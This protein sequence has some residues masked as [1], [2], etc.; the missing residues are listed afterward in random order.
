MLL[1]NRTGS[2]VVVIDG[3][4]CPHYHHPST[5]NE[6]KAIENSIRILYFT[7]LSTLIIIIIIMRSNL[8]WR[9]APLGLASA[10][11][12]SLPANTNSHKH[13]GIKGDRSTF[14]VSSSASTRCTS[15][16]TAKDESNSDEISKSNDKPKKKVSPKQRKKKPPSS[17]QE[18]RTKK[19]IKNKK[20][21]EMMEQLKT[22]LDEKKKDE[23][24]PKNLMDNL[25][26]F[27]VGQNVRKTL[28]ELTTLGT[29]LP[30]ETRQK[31]YLDERF[32]EGDSNA[33]FSEHNPFLERMQQDDYV[34]EV[35]VIGATGEVGT[36]VVRKLLLEGRFRVRVL[37]RDLYSH[38]L[39]LLGTG[40]TY[41]QGDLGN[42][43]SLEYALTDVDKIV[44]CAG[45][46]RPDERDFQEKFQYFV[47]ENLK[48]HV[49][50]GVGDHDEETVV[51]DME[52]EQLD[53]I[54]EVRA[55]LAEQVDYIGMLNLVRAYQNV[56]VAD[57]GTSQA[58][59]RTLF[60]F[61][62]RVED[63]DLFAVDEGNAFAK[64]QEKKSPEAERKQTKAP[65]ATYDYE[66][67]DEMA[68]EAPYL[69]Y[70]DEDEEGYE[71]EYGC[72]E[73]RLDATVKAQVRWIRNGLGRGVFVGKVPKGTRFGVSGEAAIV[74]SRLRSRED[75]E[76]GIDLST[77]GF[78]GF[79][80]KLVADG[81]TYE[82]FV[83]TG[84]YEEDGVEYIC[85][86]Y[87]HTKPCK[88]SNKSRNKSMIAR[89]PFNNFKPVLKRGAN[90]DM[91]DS[92]VETF[93]GKDVRN[94][95]FR[96]R[97]AS[98]DER[99]GRE[100]GENT[101][102]YMAISH[103]KVFRQQ[104]EPEFVYLSDAR[105]PREVKNGMVRHDRRRLL[106]ATEK[107]RGNREIVQILDQKALKNVKEM[108]RSEEETY[109]KFRGEETLKNSGLRW[110]RC[111]FL[112][113]V[114]Y[115]LKNVT[116]P[117]YLPLL[118]LYDHP[119]FRF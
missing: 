21:A 85:E 36:L 112:S 81:G 25:N 80:V 106:S 115:N 23:S 60:K 97:S 58:A 67:E 75:P 94:I 14:G 86:F 96:Y 83:R 98:N 63:F 22:K 93:T 59:K 7:A 5:R 38:T 76:K 18:D 88:Y 104:P 110:V 45:T 15:L 87:T 102:F 26:P 46:P 92:V 111:L 48:K 91:N 56:R 113:A 65:V 17:S 2:R 43:E 61:T 66:E 70:F 107:R 6:E 29:G 99:S 114:A 30:S 13:V 50:K 74:S 95:G 42:M 69:D 62:S 72:L 68:D 51:D 77:A 79:I 84:S 108:T 10:F 55:Q 78:G 57:Y 109:Y 54:L 27:Q 52:W 100:E 119:H 89:L 16:P 39:N 49:V 11:L 71:D 53:S 90:E 12:D 19:D 24:S 33:L 105:I 32:L 1:F 82:A 8:I 28:D 116:D 3:Y 117:L 47:K 9:L 41:C 37:V 101:S 4:G 73:Q 103:I 34:P 118:Q 40:V 31:Y 64:A 20:K 44:F 35:L